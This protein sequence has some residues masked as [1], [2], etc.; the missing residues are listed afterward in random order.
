MAKPEGIVLESK[1][2]NGVGTAEMEEEKRGPEG[3]KFLIGIGLFLVTAVV[4]VVGNEADDETGG[5][6]GEEIGGPEEEDGEF[7]R[8]AFPERSTED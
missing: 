6:I 7:S 1:G 5:P 8:G 3:E 2:G 4:V